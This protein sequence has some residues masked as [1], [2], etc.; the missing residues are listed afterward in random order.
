[1]R[2]AVLEEHGMPLRVRQ[3]DITGPREGQVRVRIAASGV[4]HSD[5]SVQNGTLLHPVP[6]V[7]GHEGS[8]IVTE[9]GPGVTGLEVGDHVVLSWITPC[10]SCHACR[11]GESHLCPNGASHMLSDHLSADGETLIPGQG[12]ATFAEETIVPEVAAVRIDEDIPLDVAALVGCGVTTGVG[13]VLNTARVAPGSNVLVVGCGGVGLSAV[14]GARLAGA[15]H[16]VAVDPVSSKRDTALRL[17]ATHA[18]SPEDLPEALRDVTGGPGFDYAF[19]VVG[20]PETIRTAW[21]ATRSGGTTVVV[22]AG[23]MTG[24]V[25]FSPFEL[26]YFERSLRGCVYGSAVP[27]RDFPRML[28]Y[29]RQGR[30]DLESLVSHHID[31]DDVNSAFDAMQ[32]GETVR[33]VIRF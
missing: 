13:A 14:Q 1:M 23:S 4:C 8:G 21:E 32:S 9:L 26:F 33:S 12:L 31:L 18:V 27:A 25:E 2:A 24:K 15:L 20:I 11:R 7:L 3:V 10:G 28:E 5:L 16:I 29:W 22:G 19:E 30:L 17:G 6:T